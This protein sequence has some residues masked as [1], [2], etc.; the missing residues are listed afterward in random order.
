MNLKLRR[1]YEVTDKVL[2]MSYD[3]KV[4]YRAEHLR[5]LNADKVIG[6]LQNY[7]VQRVA[8]ERASQKAKLQVS[9][10]RFIN[11]LGTEYKG[12][13]EGR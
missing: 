8:I 5:G 9:I 1:G 4:A 13:N 12:T 2:A 3:E 7:I 11:D 10:D 6:S